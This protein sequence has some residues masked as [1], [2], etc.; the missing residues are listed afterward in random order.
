MGGTK[1]IL[2]EKNPFLGGNS[3][4]AT[5]GINGAGSR[6]Q[7]EMGI[8]DSYEIFLEDTV[9][10]ATGVKKEHGPCPPAY[11]LAKVIAGESASAVHWIQDNFG[12]ALDT[13]SRLGGHSNLRTHR[14][15]KGGKFPG[16]EITSALMK[17]YEQL[18][19]LENGTCDLVINCNAKKLLRVDGRVTGVEYVDGDG[20]VQQV[21][22][23]AVVLAT[24]GYG[25]GGLMKGSM[26]HSIRP[27][28]VH[29]PTTNGDHSQGDGITLAMDIGAKAVGLKHVQVHPTGLVNP[30]DPDNRTKFLAAEALRGEGGILLDRD[31][32]RFCNDIGKRDYV[33]GSMWSLNKPP[34]RL[35]LNSKAAS[36]LTWHCKH[37]VS[38]RVMKHFTSGEDLAQ[39]MGISAAQLH[40]SFT[41]Y[42][43]HA[44]AGSDPFQKIY[45]AATPFDMNDSFYVAQVTPVVHYT[46]GGLAI[47]PAAECVYEETSR[48]IPGL[49]AAGE[50]AGGV[51]GRNRLGGSALLECV[52]FGRVAGDSA[53]KYVQNPPPAVRAS[54]GTT[55]ITIPQTNGAD[56]IT[57]TYGGGTGPAVAPLGEK[58]DIIEWDDEITTQ[59]GKQSTND[60]SGGATEEPVAALADA[61]ISDGQ[62][63]AVVYGSFFMGDSRRDSATIVKTFPGGKASGLGPPKAVEGNDFNFNSLKNTKFLVVCTSSMYGNPPKNF[64]E[65]YYHL[66]AASQNP[67]K[68]LKG[69]QHAVYGNGDETYYDTYMNV[70]RMIDHLLE[71]AGSR[72]FFARGETSEPHAAVGV[73]MVDAAAWSPV[74]WDAMISASPDATPVSW[75]AHW[76]GSKTNHHDKVTDWDL[77]KLEKKFGKPKSIS[78]FSTPGARL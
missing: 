55:T 40:K 66:K 33:T 19:D 7:S 75:G 49:F 77:K 47:S 74:M 58:V 57:I 31:G 32:Q 38:R 42:N 34:Y 44:T 61:D 1:V 76:D 70:P 62:D 51:H 18:A 52:V 56:P 59:V 23:D 36:N 68:P 28:L 45:F 37:Y 3:T 20:Q 53:L 67:G 72:R 60:A 15:M 2:L 11:P 5:S 39:E 12:L 64:W 22:A 73:K 69:L 10:S 13:V 48:V 24:G 30:D 9:R 29:L 6:T 43:G 16:M 63:V 21:H 27:D 26:L 41:E 71:R 78:I 25:A 65:F 17:K 35:V 46:M 4:K 50:L 14:S 54:T 8:K